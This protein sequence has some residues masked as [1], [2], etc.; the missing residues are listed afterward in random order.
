MDTYRI[1]VKI[2]NH[3]FEAEGSPEIVKEQFAS[4]K[5]MISCIPA[6]TVAPPLELIRNN[7][8]NQQLIGDQES[9][10]LDKIFRVEN[11]VISLTALPGSIL[12]ATLLTMLGQRHFR[13]NDSITGAEVKDG[14]EQSGYR[15]DRVDRFI[16]KLTKEGL[17]MKIGIGK[18]S[19]YR[20][21]NQ[22][23]ARADSLAKDLIATLP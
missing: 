8:S 23:V 10:S 5:E 7:I 16:D 2:G 19:R 18:G 15:P 12:D 14:L 13:N 9:V 17:V 11:R 1:K 22:G 21:T 6:Q 4:F 3:E 20:L